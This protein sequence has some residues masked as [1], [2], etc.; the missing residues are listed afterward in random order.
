MEKF[1]LT[2]DNVK[3]LNQLGGMYNRY[4]MLLGSQLLELFNNLG[5]ASNLYKS[6]DTLQKDILKEH[7][8]PTAEKY[9]WN[10]QDKEVEIIK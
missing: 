5:S 6:L 2:D 1:K 10:L 7:N 8:V 9:S 4:L 3:D